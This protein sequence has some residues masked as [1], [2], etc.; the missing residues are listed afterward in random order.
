[1]KLETQLKRLET[2]VAKLIISLKSDICDDYR[3]YDG[4]DKP[5]MLLTI[6]FTPEKDGRA[7]SWDYQTGDNSYTGGA[8][9][10]ANWGVG[11]IYRR[12]NSRELAKEIVGEIAEAVYSSEN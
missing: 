6:G 9:H 8:Y 10:H 7:F 5:G 1:M 4:D 2:Q 12:S 3:A 11:A